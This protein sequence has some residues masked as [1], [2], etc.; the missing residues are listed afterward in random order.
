MTDCPSSAVNATFPDSGLPET[1]VPEPGIPDTALDALNQGLILFDAKLRLLR[2]NAPYL[3]L[4]G[5]ERKAFAP[6]ASFKAI[7]AMHERQGDLAGSGQQGGQDEWLR[8]ARSRESRTTLC[9]RPDGTVLSLALK[10]LDDGRFLLL[11]DDIT[12]SVQTQIALNRS[13]R[14]LLTAVENFDHGIKIVDGDGRIVAWNRRYQDLMEIPAHLLQQGAEDAEIIRFVN[15]REG[16][17]EEAV[18]RIVALRARQRHK[19]ESVELTRTS[20]QGRVIQQKR[21][22]MPDG[23]T[24]TTYT[25]IT[26]LRQAEGALARQTELLRM[27][28]EHMEQGVCV[29]DHQLRVVNFNRRWQELF[30]LPPSVARTGTHYRDFIRFQAER[31]DYGPGDVDRLTAERLDRINPGQ[32]YRNQIQK[33]DGRCIAI[34]RTPTPHGGFL[35]TYT[36]VTIRWRAEQQIRSFSHLLETTFN[37]INQGLAVYDA[38]FRLLALNRRFRDMFNMPEDAVRIGMHHRDMLRLLAETG[39]Y[40]Q[41]DLETLVAQRMRQIQPGTATSEE[42]ERPNGQV[43]SI[44]RNPMPGGGFV[45]TFTDITEVRRAEREAAETGQLL[46]TA[47]TSMAQ[48]IV[49]HDADHR[50]LAFNDRY[51]ETRRSL[52]S[53]F[54]K[55]GVHQSAILRFQAERGDFG[56]GPVDA[57]VATRLEC[58]DNG[59]VLNPLHQHN[60]R[61]YQVDRQKMPDGGTITTYSDITELKAIESELIKAKNAAEAASKA[62]SDFLSNMSHELRTPLNAVIGFSE[63]MNRESFGPLGNA[64]YR[65]YASAI[66]ESGQHLLSLINDILD[67]SRIEAG[68]ML[69]EEEPVDLA[70]LIE[71]CLALLDAE[72]R[73]ASL[74]TERYLDPAL[75]AVRGDR[76]RLKQILL[77]LLQNAIKF[78]PAGGTVRVDAAPCA[79]GGVSVL[80]SDTGI[81]IPTEEIPRMLERFEQVES[82]M[83]R[84]YE[85]AG[86]GLPLAKTLV[87]LHGGQLEIDSASGEGTRVRITLPQDRVIPASRPQKGATDQETAESAG[88]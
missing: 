34:R 76:R 12:G 38:D 2:A 6:G 23:G 67:F 42:R 54:L 60:G 11:L 87:E 24:F 10:P 20:V 7:I 66:T 50:I 15:R 5:F 17:G 1:G 29:F 16:L 46:G 48:G 55:P 21:S 18:E 45:T 13:A 72:I 39:E 33:P 36:D 49:I 40:G 63:I 37:A 9:H 74:I 79:K 70:R 53:H 85:G 82:S 64:Q 32:P 14:M 44:R 47:L 73:K 84:R 58:M 78:T 19:G 71:S 56:P 27:T 86:L 25:D 83:K 3:R 8:A 57:L 30:D 75:P 43:L 51:L 81:G 52:P 26:N 80:I 68:H 59:T 35:C 61:I 69:I 22:P 88:P 65:D 62:K 77:N 4:G 28:Q 41:G 31:G